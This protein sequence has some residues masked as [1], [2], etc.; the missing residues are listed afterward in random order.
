[1]SRKK[2]RSYSV[3]IVSDATTTNKTFSISSNLLRN[4]IIGMVI[5]L[6]SFGYV[7]FDY[8]TV[9]FNRQKYI[10]LQGTLAKKEDFI[11]KID[12]RMKEINLN[13]QRAKEDKKKIMVS[14]GLKSPNA[15]KRVEVGSGG[16]SSGDLVESTQ[17][18]VINEV[19]S[20][21]KD[22]LNQANEYQA[23][24]LQISNQ[25]QQAISFHEERKLYLAGMPSIWPTIGYYTDGFGWRIHPITLKR[26]FH[27]G[28]DIA[29]QLGNEVVATANG[30]VLVAEYQTYLGNLVVIDHM[31]G[32]TTMYGHLASY[33]VKV[34][35][36]VKRGDVIGYVGNTGRSSAPHLHYEIRYRDEPQDPQLFIMD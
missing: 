30:T 14:L 11:K 10:K 17:E 20:N 26:N 1:M 2:P 35:D 15:L 13:L 12:S 5:I 27:H 32:Y 22:L 28:Q 16:G 19:V 4:L 23:Q 21:E 24:S 33:T 9:S 31:Y 7:I 25:L 18:K 36:S 29:A 34:G 8:L 6:F 3:I